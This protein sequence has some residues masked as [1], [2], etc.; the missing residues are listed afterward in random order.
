MERSM[1]NNYEKIRARLAGKGAAVFQSPYMPNG[2]I[3]ATAIMIVFNALLILVGQNPIY[4]SDFSKAIS[5]ITWVRNLLMLHP[6]AFAG[7]C[8]LYLLIVWLILQVLTRSAALIVWMAAAFLHLSLV[9]ALLSQIFKL[10]P[11]GENA[12][13]TVSQPILAGAV[14][15]L[16]LSTLLLRS[17]KKIVQAEHSGSGI[18]VKRLNL[19]QGRIWWLGAVSLVLVLIVSGVWA[20]ARP[21]AGWQLV[22][23]EHT[24]GNRC[25]S[26]SA[27]DLNRG[28]GVVFGGSRE[29]MG[30]MLA[31]LDETW[32]WT[33][34][35]WVEVETEIKPSARVKSAMAFD[36]ARG[37]MVM[38]GGEY[39]DL[40][41]SDT[42]EY[43][44]VTWKQITTDS[45]MSPPARSSHQLFFDPTRQ[46]V[47][48][49]GGL[50]GKDSEGKF[51][52]YS[53]AWEWD[54]QKWQPISIETTDYF[55]TAHTT[56]WDP[57]RQSIL[58]MNFDRA[59]IW[60]GNGWDALDGENVPSGRLSARMVGLPDGVLL[61]GGIQNDV[62]TDETWLLNGSE[63]VRSKN[64]LR[65]TARSLPVMFYEPGENRVILYGGD[66][67][68]SPYLD[69]MWEYK[70]P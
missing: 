20:A 8:L 17:P 69:D 7:A 10:N 24:P 41:L 31:P 65:P 40:W 46:K 4:W 42:W 11:D 12:L 15:G 34:T 25:C 1:G 16:L 26:A 2:L 9:L 30:T 45:Y 29:W 23:P 51:I 64:A 6:L 53:D 14:I 3:I 32:E 21:R 54:G 19:P 5:D 60:K 27:Y 67:G 63:W 28:R 48:A 44:G 36:Q 55:L 18:A 66:G 39:K 37:V 33:G 61:F 56:A 49:T 58:A 43:D 70:L 50:G 22:K 68:S 38:F 62:L 57:V 59:L 35:D 52:F 47:V 13:L